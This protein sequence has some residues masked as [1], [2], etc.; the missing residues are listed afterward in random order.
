MIFFSF[1]FAI[2]A[3]IFFTLFYA[4]PQA[5]IR[6]FL[7]LISCVAFHLFFAGPAGVI[8][9]AAIGVLTY[10]AGLTQN[11]IACVSV[12]VVCVATLVFYKYSIFISNELIGIVS[13]AL[14]AYSEKFLLGTLPAAPPLGIS[15]FTFEFVHYLYEIYKGGR[16][17]RSPASFAI[18]SIFW[19]SLVA[20]PIKRY[21]SFLSGLNVGLSSTNSEN[22]RVGLSLVAIG[23][24]KK[25]A[26]D[27]LS[28]WIVANEAQVEKLGLIGAWGFVIAISARILLDFSGYS[29][30]AIGFARMMGIKLPPNFNWPYL[31]TSLNEFWRRWHISLS[32]WIRD[33]L[34][35]PLGGNRVSA[36]R[37]AF[38][39]ITAM[40]I[41]GLWHGAAW[42][43][44]VWGFY[45]GIGLVVST[46]AGSKI[47]MFEKRFLLGRHHSFSSAFRYGHNFFGWISTLV[48]VG[49]GWVLFFY[50]LDRAM[51]IFEVLVS[52]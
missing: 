6:Y 40:V 18:F 24:V 34:Y 37:R 5:G 23:V 44:V 51:T 14:K 41:I 21:R 9:I 3:V 20:G 17:I 35:I 31:A 32:S 26:G 50:P 42:N 10:L 48:F 28:L 13:P 43:F 1:Y 7:L 2:G 29:D 4:I 22:A 27:A 8:P 46:A 25:I 36:G 33:Y 12:G 49:I 15:F 16:P 11:K 47:E 38:N 30:M 45:H 39:L 52:W 19:P